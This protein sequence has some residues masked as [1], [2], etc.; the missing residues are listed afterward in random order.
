MALLAALA[1][2]LLACLA[3]G[4][5]GAQGALQGAPAP[6]RPWDGAAARVAA[7]E[8]SHAAARAAARAAGAPRV[9]RSLVQVGIV[10]SLTARGGAYFARWERNSRGWQRDFEVRS[11]SCGH[12][13]A[14]LLRLRAPSSE[15]FPLRTRRHKGGGVVFAPLRV[16]GKHGDVVGEGPFDCLSKKWKVYVCWAVGRDPGAQDSHMLRCA[17]CWP[18][19]MRV[20]VPL[21]GP[22][23]M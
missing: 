19:T 2:S 4:A 15:L 9:P 11:A 14:S 10:T 22:A 16:K 21:E 3:A 20:L 7:A 5:R 23:P 1:A 8:A 17:L 13:G 18:Y 6:P 12:T